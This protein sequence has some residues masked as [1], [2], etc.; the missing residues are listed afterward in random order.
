MEAAHTVYATSIAKGGE[1]DSYL[2][3]KKKA[4]DYFD[5]LVVWW[6]GGQFAT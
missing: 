4:S 2:I 6:S 5:G 3:R 1:G